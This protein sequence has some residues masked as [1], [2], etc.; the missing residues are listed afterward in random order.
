VQV[1]KEFLRGDYCLYGGAGWW[2]Y[3]FC[4]GKKGKSRLVV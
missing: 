1:V 4:Y 2:K 3:E